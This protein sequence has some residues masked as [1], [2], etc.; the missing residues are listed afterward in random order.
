MAEPTAS[1]SKLL[2]FGVIGS[3]GLVHSNGRI[4][5]EQHALLRG[6]QALK[7]Y[8]EMADNDAIIGSILRV[9]RTWLTQTPW[10]I[11]PADESSQE[12]RDWADFIETC[13]ADMSHTWADFVSELLSYM[14]YGFSYYE[15]CYKRREGPNEDPTKRSA[16]ND[17][18]IG[19]RKFA[20]RSQ[21]S[22]ECWVFDSDQG[23]R[24]AMQRRPGGGSSVFLPIEK[25]LLFRTMTGTNSPEGV[26]LLRSSVRSYLYVKRFQNIEAVGLERDLA[27]LPVI[28]APPELFDPSVKGE[29]KAAY[30]KI[31]A[32]L[33]D[34]VTAIRR[35]EREGLVVPSEDG[36]DGKTGYRL[37][38]LTSAGAR[39]FNIGDTIRRYQRDMAGTMLAEFVLIGDKAGSYAMV[40]SKTNTFAVSL[41]SILNSVAEVVNRYAIARLCAINGCPT[42]L[43]PTLK[44]G[45]VAARPITEVAQFVLQMSQAGMLMY[46]KATERWIRSQMGMPEPEE[47][48]LTEPMDNSGMDETSEQTETDE[49]LAADMV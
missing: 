12:A 25:C 10:F 28:E 34:T 3:S 11:V 31:L 33:L 24:G 19:W 21:D 14:V 35:D 38:L 15:V 47:E 36:P 6:G 43:I 8:Q 39:Q 16:Y 23:I 17:G 26:S 18:Y 22:I 48:T 20:V 4:D 44:V 32:N 45:D 29:L 41:R 37:R 2:D 46:S 13:R 42:E 1:S 27:G 5:N 49:E 40:D 30:N 7:L 9:S